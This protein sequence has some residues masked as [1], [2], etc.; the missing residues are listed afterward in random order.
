MYAR[1]SFGLDCPAGTAKRSADHVLRR[2]PAVLHL[3]RI[4]AEGV[5]RQDIR[6]SAQ[7]LAMDAFDQGRVID[8]VFLRDSAGR[9]SCLLQHR[10]HGSVKE[11]HLFS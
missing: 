8:I 4:A 2:I 1:F 3:E 5:G 6:A 9:H 7:I 11:E 10:S